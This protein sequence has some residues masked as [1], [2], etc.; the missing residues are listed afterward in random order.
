M[1]APDSLEPWFAF[2]VAFVALVWWLV[3]E[4]RAAPVD[5]NPEYSRLD[6]LDGLPHD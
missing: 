1:L 5:P 6:L 2:L 4:F 3:L